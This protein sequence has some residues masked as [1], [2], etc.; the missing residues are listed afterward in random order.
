MSQ[1]YLHTSGVFHLLQLLRRMV[2]FFQSG[3]MNLLHGAPLVVTQRF[4][5]VERTFEIHVFFDTTFGS[6]ERRFSP[7][8]SQ[9]NTNTP[10]T[11][12]PC[13]APCCAR[14]PDVQHVQIAFVE[15]KIFHFNRIFEITSR[16][17][18]VRRFFW[19]NF[20]NICYFLATMHHE[21]L[22]TV[23]LNVVKV[24]CKTD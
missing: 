18:V 17:T 23:G 24:R 22:R 12:T 21:R 6:P 11:T 3:S 13:S 14:E 4:V 9:Y 15:G 20:F 16:K 1:P 10:T 7:S 2:I 19:N 8:S 5:E